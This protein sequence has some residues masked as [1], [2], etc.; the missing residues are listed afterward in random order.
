MSK[1]VAATDYTRMPKA[2]LIEKLQHLERD[3]VRLA[4]AGTTETTMSS[5][6]ND[7]ERRF[8]NFAEIASDWGY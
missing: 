6:S 4:Q 2:Q 8:R 5:M 3:V 1:S 7:D